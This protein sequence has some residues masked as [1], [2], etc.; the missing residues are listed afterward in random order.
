MVQ[1]SG[2]VC[3][4]RASMLTFPGYGNMING[5]QGYGCYCASGCRDPTMVCDLPLGRCH[6][7]AMKHGVT[8]LGRLATVGTIAIDMF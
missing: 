8:A 7:G 3:S 1:V 5:R 6:S 4:L 2:K